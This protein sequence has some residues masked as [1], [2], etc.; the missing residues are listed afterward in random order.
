[1][2]NMLYNNN[3]KIKVI[4]EE[5]NCFFV[6]TETKMSH[7]NQKK[8]YTENKC[9]LLVDLHVGSMADHSLHDSEMYLVNTKG[10][11]QVE[12]ERK[13][14]GWVKCHVFVVSE[15]KVNIQERQ[16]KSVEL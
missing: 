14:R 1:M 7:M 16:L 10:L 9:R 2:P 3:I 5:A 13:G 6:K 4:L 15:L 12:L 8:F 11:R